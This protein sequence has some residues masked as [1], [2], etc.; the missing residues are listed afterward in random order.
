MK[1]EIRFEINDH[2]RIFDKDAEEVVY[3]SIDQCSFPAIRY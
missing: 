3:D 2:F 1:Q